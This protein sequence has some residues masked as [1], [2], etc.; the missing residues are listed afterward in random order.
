MRQ[1]DQDLNALQNDFVASLSA[2]AGHKANST[3]IVFVA[4]VVKTLC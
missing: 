2:N 3:S 4:W 1:I